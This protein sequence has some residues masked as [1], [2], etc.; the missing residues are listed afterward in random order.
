MAPT[1]TCFGNYQQS[2]LFATGGAIAVNSGY[3]PRSAAQPPVPSALTIV[4]AQDYRDYNYGGAVLTV[5]VTGSDCSTGANYGYTTMPSGWNDDIG[6]VVT[7]SNCGSALFQDANYGGAKYTTSRN[8]QSP[9]LGA[10]NDRGSSQY[11]S[12]NV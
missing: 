8:S 12:Y 11:F 1:E 10:L 3:A 2:M 6:S 5:T 7:K 4:V 9:S